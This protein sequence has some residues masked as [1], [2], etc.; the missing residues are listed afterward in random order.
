MSS[1][2]TRWLSA[3]SASRWTQQQL[4]E[5]KRVF[6]AT[7]DSDFLATIGKASRT[8]LVQTRG[9][10]QY[11]RELLAGDVINYQ[12]FIG[13][14]LAIDHFKDALGAEVKGFLSEAQSTNELPTDL[15]LWTLDRVTIASTPVALPDGTTGT[16]HTIRENDEGQYRHRIYY[17]PTGMTASADFWFVVYVKKILNDWCLLQINTYDGPT[18]IPYAYINLTTLAVGQNAGASNLSVTDIGDGWRRIAFKWTNGTFGNPSIR[19]CGAEADGDEQYTGADA[20]AYYVFAPQVKP[21]DSSII[22]GAAGTSRLKTQLRYEGNDNIGGANGATRTISCKVVVPIG[23]TGGTVWSISDGGSS[24]TRIY[25]T[26]ES[27]GKARVRTAIP[28]GDTGD[29]TGTSDLRDGEEHSIRILLAEDN[30][31]LIVDGVEESGPGD[32]S[33]D[34]VTGLDRWDIGHDEGANNHLNAT[35]TELGPNYETLETA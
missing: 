24:A 20:D 7:L 35:I 28:A 29:V 19:I 27:D 34:L 32:T 14:N 21:D 6:F 16:A 4:A 13:D 11:G 22:L 17:L 31:K 18:I 3:S 15:T 23:S 33:V 12:K 8:P 26:I 2:A 10:D 5:E 30:L 1:S 9:S 25:L